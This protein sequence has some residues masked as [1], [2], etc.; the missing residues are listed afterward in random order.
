MTSY[1]ARG[2]YLEV[3]AGESR[4]LAAVVMSQQDGHISLSFSGAHI[5]QLCPSGVLPQGVRLV[6]RTMSMSWP[7]VVNRCAFLLLSSPGLFGRGKNSC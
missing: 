5:S 3:I 4:A 1:K 2:H 7:S 6:S